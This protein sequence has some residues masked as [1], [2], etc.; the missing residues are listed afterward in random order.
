[1][2]YISEASKEKYWIGHYPDGEGG[3][4]SKKEVDEFFEKKG[5]RKPSEE[6]NQPDPNLLTEFYNNNF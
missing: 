1:M 2:I 4:F 5:K 6:K 3:E